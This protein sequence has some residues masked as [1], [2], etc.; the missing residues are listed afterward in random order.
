VGVSTDASTCPHCGSSLR[1]IPIPD[2]LGYAQSHHKV[3]FN[4]DCSYYREGW[5][6]MQDHYAATA[7]YR[8][9]VDPATG[10]AF[11]LPVWSESA[12]TDKIVDEEKKT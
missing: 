8:Y 11:P 10:V 2:E 7:S 6:W 5:A 4:N 3:C 1:S 9:R 12:L